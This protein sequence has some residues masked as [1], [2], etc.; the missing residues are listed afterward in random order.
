[1]TL[2]S[3]LPADRRAALAA[4]MPSPEVQDGAAL[5][6][7]IGG[8]T[9]LAEALERALGPQAGA[10]A[11]TAI[12]HRI[13]DA[14][15]LAVNNYHGSI[16]AFS[17]D[18][19]TAWFGDDDG[20]AAAACA[21]ATQSAMASVGRIEAPGIG[22]IAIGLKVTVTARRVR[23]FQVG[24][25]GIQLL[26][27]ILGGTVDRPA[28]GDYLCRAGEVLVDQGVAERLVALLRI[29]DWREQVGLRFARCTGVVADIPQRP[30]A[31]V[32]DDRIASDV[33]RAW[34]LPPLCQRM[35][36]AQGRFLAEF[37]PVAALFAKFGGLGHETD[38]YAHEHLDAFIRWAM[39][40]V[41]RHGGFMLHVTIGDKGSYFFAAFG[42]PVAHGDD[43]RR[44]V[45]A[46]HELRQLPPNLSGAISAIQI[47]V[48]AGRV[49]AGLYS[50]SRSVYTVAGDSANLAARLMAAA[51]PGQVL[52]S[53]HMGAGLDRRFAIRALDPIAI[54]GR[55]T[56]VAICELLGPV[57]GS[58]HLKEPRYPL[59]IIGRGD[60]IGAIARAIETVQSG[61]SRAGILRRCWHRQIAAGQRGHSA[62][63]LCLA[64][65]LCRRM[66]ILWHGHCLPALAGGM[67]RVVR[68]DGRRS[69]RSPGAAFVRRA[70]RGG[71]AGSA[72]RSADRRQ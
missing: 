1:M 42:A 40:V 31:A 55:N 20:R 69:A 12:V 46:A 64:C 34:I 5:F 60:E 30:W 32:P 27:C 52:L 23:R 63:K 66:P 18:A 36:S 39:G 19:I 13:F 8:F 53:V 3:F 37:R 47:G 51:A 4:G 2:A 48:N 62:R 44:V 22:A 28:V 71:G 57:A 68:I 49:Y 9:P 26:D 61:R 15:V 50:G 24:D 38:P 17:G 11:L 29:D 7:D 58:I 56:P 14:L 43:G 33:L 6:A 16:I 25:P 35:Q 45:A 21:L 70:R 72:A 10:E 65:V 67:E 54:K 59:P 41:M